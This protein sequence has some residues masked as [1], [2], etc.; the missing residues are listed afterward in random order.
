[1][2]ENPLLAGNHAPVVDELSALDLPITGA[3]PPQLCGRLLRNGPNPINP[4]PASYHHFLGDGM[5]HAV[6]LRDGRAV[7]YR[8]RWVRTDAACAQLG[9]TPPADQPADP[10]P[11]ISPANT[12]VVSH[13][14]RILALV[15][16]GLPTE[17]DPTLATCGRF[18]F[19][20]RLRSAMTAHPKIDPV[21][22]ELVFFGYGPFG[23]PFLRYHVADASGA[24]IRTEEID[25]ARPTMM[26]DFAITGRY[27][28]FLD[29]PVVLD[30][31]LFG[32]GNLPFRWDPEAGAWVG[33]MPR[34]GGAVRWFEIE[35]CYVFHTLNAYDDGDS[36]VLDV[37]RYP[38]MFGPEPEPSTLDRWTIDLVTGRIREQRLDDR[39]QEM[40][41]VDDRV[42]GAPHRYGYTVRNCTLI[43]HDLHRG[44][45][46]PAALEPGQCASEPVFVPGGDGEDDGWVL[47]VVYDATRDGSDLVVLDA[48]DFTAA[49]VARVQLP[50]R[51]PDGF[52]GSW[53]P[54]R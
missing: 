30:M 31:S 5:V 14:G 32:A 34:A 50:Q 1:M 16:V 20:G 44:T 17:L 41:R 18:D 11:G 23:P 27:A 7:S 37:V 25:I 35:P 45:G 2:P 3:L 47:S 33:V 54:Q 39:A 43:K 46:E 26:H 51:V 42:V 6:E 8:N 15:E 24:L 9:E 49:P 13:A 12:H 10:L 19:N 36:V 52:H 22:G 21:T 28:V 29:L 38:S 40:P 4:D 53:L 48:S